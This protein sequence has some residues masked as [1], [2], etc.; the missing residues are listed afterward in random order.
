MSGGGAVVTSSA[1]IVA[2]NPGRPPAVTPWIGENFSGG[3]GGV[4][5]SGV[6]R[7]DDVVGVVPQA[8]W[9]N[10]AGA[11][12][13][14]VPLV[15]AEGASTDLVMDESISTGVNVNPALSAI[16]R[17]WVAAA[18]PALEVQRDTAPAGS[19]QFFRL[20]K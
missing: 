6:L 15:D 20:R 2:V 10:L 11:T 18:A 17:V 5:P 1:A 19:A 4:G 14:E 9:N 3:A 16:Q 7:A 8:N 13:T 12:D